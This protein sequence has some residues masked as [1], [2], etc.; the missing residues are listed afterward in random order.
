MPQERFDIDTSHSSVGFT[1]RHM[2]I[3]KVHGQ[4]TKWSGSISL[5]P[6]DL[7][8][9]TVEVDVDVSSIDTRDAQRDTH[10]KSA[11]FFEVEKFPRM[12]FKSSKVE[13]AA[14]NL[15]VHGQLTLHGVTKDVVLDAEYGGRG[16]DPWG[17]ERVAFAAKTRIDRRDYGLKWNQALEAGGVLV[18]ENVD[19]VLEVEA[20]KAG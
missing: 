15:K 14:P 7:T 16:K 5:D 3:A 6:A 17:G 9:A 2:V 19:I 20:K 4:F 8:T 18:S 12:T 1:V 11:D 13:G 10:L